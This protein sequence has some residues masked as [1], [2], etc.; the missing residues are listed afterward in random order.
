MK[1]VIEIK[2]LS[3]AYP[4]GKFAIK[5][6]NLDIF[7]NESIGIIGP[8]GA[9]KTT[10]LLHL[11]GILQGKGQIKILDMEMHKKNLNNIRS[12]VG[13]VFQNPDD[14][15]FSLNV[16]DDVSFGPLNMKL[17]HDTVIKRTKEALTQVKMEGFENHFSYHLSFGEK[18]R[19]SLATILAMKPKI[20]ILDE[21][22]SNLD[23]QLRKQLIDLLKKNKTTMIIASHDLEMVLELCQRVIVLNQGK[24]II[25]GKT[26]TIMKDKNI[27]ESNSLEV[28]FSI[29][30][31]KS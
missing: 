18:K 16:F 30:F 26:T 28:P 24:I 17:P 14:H 3:Y 13:I 9:G 8:N 1:K 15:L 25:D 4:N 31:Q 27:M 20:L 12:K 11:N 7:E 19:I 2:N 6:I 10:L 22:T 23:P 29:R 21:P 5:N